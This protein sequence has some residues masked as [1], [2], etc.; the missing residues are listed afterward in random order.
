MK[1]F[2]QIYKNSN[3]LLY[4]V[5]ESKIKKF[6]KTNDFYGDHNPE[7][8]DVIYVSTK[9]DMVL[10]FARSL[11]IPDDYF[12]SKE[13][14]DYLETGATEGSFYL[15]YCKAT[16]PLNIFNPSNASDRKKLNNV[17]E[18][19]IEKMVNHH[20]WFEMEHFM[21]KN[22]YLRKEYDGF[23]TAQYEYSNLGV[24]HP[25]KNLKI[26]KY[27]KLPYSYLKDRKVKNEIETSQFNTHKYANDGGRSEY[28]SL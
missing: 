25:E 18:F 23:V 21:S 8:P 17:D 11:F 6:V 19:T 28:L 15:Y 13:N 12:S 5:S 3:K 10:D 26:L 1:L 16:K 2:E 4:H 7:C 24:F 27:E 9:K 20:N 22:S 14:D